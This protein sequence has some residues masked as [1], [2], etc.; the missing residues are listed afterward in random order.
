MSEPGYESQRR[1]AAINY[2]L[3][4]IGL[5]SGKETE[6]WNYQ[7]YPELGDR[8]PTQ[9]WLAGDEEGVRKVVDAWYQ[10]TRAAVEEH[11]RDP[12]FLAMI[13]RKIDVRRARL[14]RAL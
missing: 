6:W 2:L 1:A 4:Q 12:E 5:S 11:R 14:S 10:E 13:R 8:T 7:T 3:G 9:A